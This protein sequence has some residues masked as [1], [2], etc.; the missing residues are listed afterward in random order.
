MMRLLVF[1]IFIITSS[2]QGCGTQTTKST[3]LT[4]P[5]NQAIRLIE[6]GEYLLAADL[7]LQLAQSYPEKSIHYRLKAADNYTKAG[8][9]YAA[10]TILEN[11]DTTTPDEEFLLRILHARISLLDGNPAKA[12]AWLDIAPPVHSSK[13][14]LIAYYNARIEMYEL[15][16]NHFKAIQDRIKISSLFQNES[17][18]TENYRK[19]WVS[20]NKLEL[21]E[22]KQLRLTA[23]TELISWIELAIINQS[24]LFQPDFLQQAISM[25]ETKYAGHPAIPA[26]TRDILYISQQYNTHPKHIAL[27]LPISGQYEKASHAIR[28]GFL[29]AWF[30]STEYKPIIDIYDT[31]ALNILTVYETAINN[32]ADFI[33]GPLEKSAIESLLKK[34]SLEITTLTLNQVHIPELETIQSTSDSPVPTLIQFGLPPEDE[35]RQVAHKAFADGHRRALVIT[36]NDAWGLRLHEAFQ[37]EWQ[38]Y[39]GKITEYISYPPRTR[40]YSS[41][42]KAL[43]NITTSEQRTRLLQQKLNRRIKSESRLRQDADMIF[44]AATPVSARQIV[45]QFRFHRAGE[46][47]V[48]ATS[49]IYTGNV[50]PQLDNDMN[51]VLFTDMP[52]LLNHDK[53]PIQQTIGRN[54]ST[55]DSAYKRFHALGIDAYHLI[56]HIGKLALQ[57]SVNFPGKTGEL[58]MGVG[59]FIQRKL[60]WAEFTNGKPLLLDDKKYP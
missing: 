5:E 37:D 32:G 56:P 41:P 42:V 25:W 50:N 9:Q 24:M 40:D 2:I 36:P 54:R 23:D 29:A 4:D 17:E 46:I 1:G 60:L 12:N 22:L 18:K 21:T 39:G 14:L 10:K 55:G 44:M 13:S 52:W 27:C 51:G 26:I 20:L 19:I 33:V 47:P 53:E 15:Q 8:D 38:S 49:H 43:L 48:Y 35:A 58:Y 28:D 3:R 6:V 11:V 57:N 34:G 45:P 59:G 30:A 7:Y 16:K 31:N